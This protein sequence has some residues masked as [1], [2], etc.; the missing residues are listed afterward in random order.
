MW[1]NDA[2]MNA[3]LERTDSTA[4]RNVTVKMVPAAMLPMVS[5]SVFLVSPDHDAKVELAQ[6]NYTDQ[7]VNMSASVIKKIQSCATRGLATASVSQ[8]GMERPAPVHACSSSMGQSAPSHVVAKTTAPATLSTAHASVNQASLA[9]TAASGV[10]QASLEPTA[11]RTAAVRTMEFVHMSMAFV[12]VRQAM[13]NR[14][15]T[16]CVLWARMASTAR[17]SASASMGQPATQSPDSAPAHLGTLESSASSNVI[18]GNMDRIAKINASATGHIL[19]DATTSLASACVHLASK[20]CLVK[21]SVH[22]ASGVPHAR[23]PATARTTPRAIQRLAFAS[24]NG[25]GLARIA[26]NHAQL[27][28]LA[29]TAR[30]NVQSACTA[31]AVHATTSPVNASAAL[32]TWA[33]GAASLALWTS[34]ATTALRSACANMEASATL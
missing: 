18:M 34:G 6:T 15:A 32:D 30:R 16:N 31:M 10:L 1:V 12:S 19:W 33:C 24:V 29:R 23:I 20:E 28:T 27:A 13:P 17:A 3:L 21:A 11:P 9:P 25:D 26:V 5:A 7:N 2:R 14:D 22:A 8:A 4:A